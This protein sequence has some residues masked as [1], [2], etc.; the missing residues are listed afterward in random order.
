MDQPSYFDDLPF[1]RA[2]ANCQAF[3]LGVGADEVVSDSACD[4]AEVVGRRERIDSE[5]VTLMHPLF[6]HMK[7][8]ILVELETTGG[9]ADA[10]A[11]KRKNSSQSL[12]ECTLLK[13]F[14]VP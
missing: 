7:P 5:D 9:I 12:E 6:R 2:I 10:A 4:L 3:S 11:R 14:R 1:P 8:E 13:E